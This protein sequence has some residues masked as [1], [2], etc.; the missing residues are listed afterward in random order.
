MSVS[1]RS[2][3]VWYHGLAFRLRRGR[4]VLGAVFYRLNVIHI[5]SLG[6]PEDPS[7]KRP[8]DA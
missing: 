7:G 4:H 2:P 6:G 8:A 5:Q 1:R 3:G